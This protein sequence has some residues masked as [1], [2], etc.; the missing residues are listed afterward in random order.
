MNSKEGHHLDEM[1]LLKQE[2]NSKEARHLEEIKI[3]KKNMKSIDSKYTTEL[4]TLKDDIKKIKQILGS[5]Q[6]R[7]LAKNFLNRYSNHLTDED[8]KIFE[9]EKKNGLH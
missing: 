4:N 2:M 8:K 7:N 6:V 9:K 1:K 5:I 3:Q